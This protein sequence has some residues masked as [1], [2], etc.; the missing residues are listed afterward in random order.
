VLRKCPH[1]VSTSTLAQAQRHWKRLVD[2]STLSTILLLPAWAAILSL[3]RGQISFSALAQVLI[4]YAVL[5]GALWAL[6]GCGARSRGIGCACRYLMLAI[7]FALGTETLFWLLRTSLPDPAFELLKSVPLPGG[8]VSL[9]ACLA[10]L[11]LILHR[12]ALA[13]KAWRLAASLLWPLPIL[14]LAN[15]VWAVAIA[16]GPA[17]DHGDVPSRRVIWLVLDELDL[18][19]LDSNL[20][21]L[22][23]F[24][25]LRH[26][27]LWAAAAYAPASHT[28]QSVPILWTGEHIDE[29]ATTS[30]GWLKTRRVGESEWDYRW[31]D[32]HTIFKAL[33]DRGLSVQ[34][35]GWALNYCGN[36]AAMPR[37][38]C[39]DDRPYRAPGRVLGIWNW[40]FSENGLVDLLYDVLIAR[41]AHSPPQWYRANQY[42]RPS[43]LGILRMG[44]YIDDVERNADRLF[45]NKT[46]ALVF[47]HLPCPH[48]PPYDLIRGVPP[49][50]PEE[51]YA[52]NLA[53]CDG[54][55]G[56]VLTYSEAGEGQ[57][58]M[59]IVTSDHW[60][61]YDNMLRGG[62]VAA[63]GQVQ[64]PIPF[65][66]LLHGAD[67]SPSILYSRSFNIRE[68][69]ALV[70][71]YLGGR[72]SH[73]EQVRT[74]LD[75]W[76]DKGGPLPGLR[77]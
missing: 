37:I 36:V 52:R 24:T 49:G 64:R 21:A 77:H 74:V 62:G 9:Y 67:Q 10:A 76:A 65:A 34:I 26:S 12:L 54:L 4:G 51:D 16:P 66:V 8:R 28:R 71:A 42:Y 18:G 39:F 17:P 48:L 43:D 3:P 73:Y 45:G 56:R 70:E 25:K 5:A 19:Y 11:A 29:V 27:A 50:T 14:L 2:A 41:R 22:P 38:A 35:I 58:T 68:T 46:A 75:S 23:T 6:G 72:I 60:F 31:L 47:A 59:V 30:S 1:A 61:R 57:E 69:R 15:T 55:V 44:A 40:L 20:Q 13:S 53:R 63:Y 7:V 33:A 32:Q